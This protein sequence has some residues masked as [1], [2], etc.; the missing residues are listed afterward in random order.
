VE[1]ILDQ[2]TASTPG[3][4]LEEKTVSVAWHY[5]QADPEFGAR[6]AHEL[7]MLLG[8]ALSNQPLEVVE[9]KHV[10]EI[11]LRGISKAAVAHRTAFD[12][13]D[14]IIAIGDDQTDEDLFRA[15]PPSAVT[16][17]VGSAQSAARYHVA[18]CGAVR[19]LLRQVVLARVP[20]GGL[21]SSA[22]RR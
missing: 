14:G 3:S 19:T 15:L 1:G 22:G 21:R 13:S 17:A 8:E 20:V 6:Q 9:G 10:I 18:N 16:I 11:R 4:R 12:V 7:R 2:F 5:R